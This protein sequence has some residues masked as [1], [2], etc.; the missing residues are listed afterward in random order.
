MGAILN[1]TTAIDPLKTLGEVHVLLA[2]HGARQIL[3]DYDEGMPC[4]V[5]FSLKARGDEHGYHLPVNA[6]AV[7][8]TL[9]ALNE[10]G[11]MAPRYVSAQ[12]A[13]RV[14]WRIIKDWLEAQLAIVQT[15][16]VALDE[17]FLPY[18][19]VDGATLYNTLVERHYLLPER[20]LTAVR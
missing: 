15:N 17:V 1:Y 8:R 16:M 4:G 7:L 14:A 12:Q 20:T 9:E 6:A 5:S 18:L 11:R 19:L 10:Q 13:A 3:T 2:K